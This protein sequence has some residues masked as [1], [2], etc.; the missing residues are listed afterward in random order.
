M[1]ERAFPSQYDREHVGEIVGG[2]GDWI[3][4]HILRLCAKADR[5]NLERI[6]LGFPEHV[7]AFETW[8]DGATP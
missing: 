2:H 8:R 5:V 6:R 1:R 7:E 3:S 4:A